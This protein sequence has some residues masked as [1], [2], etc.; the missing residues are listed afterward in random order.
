MDYNL[1]DQDTA[2]MLLHQMGAKVRTNHGLICKVE[3]ST[4]DMDIEYI[5]TVSR[6]NEFMLQRIK[7]Y[8]LGAGMFT[9]IND[10]VE[11]IKYDIDRLSN[12]SNSKMFGMFV[13]ENKKLN[14]IIYY[15]ESL[16]LHY[17][18]PRDDMRELD[19]MVVELEKK[20]VELTHNCPEVKI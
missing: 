14:R 4:E 13:S 17:N 11:Y 8:P 2:T 6:K 12:A 20:I 3:F 10:L 16:F 15:L 9:S 18:V 19:E 1:I 5:Y 7:P